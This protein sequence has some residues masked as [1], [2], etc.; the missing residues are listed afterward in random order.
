MKEKYNI[1]S[2]EPRPILDTASYCT[3]TTSDNKVNMQRNQTWFDNW[4]RGVPQ[5]AVSCCYSPWRDRRGGWKQSPL[6]GSCLRGW[7][8]T[9][10]A[11]VDPDHFECG[12]K[13]SWWFS[14]ASTFSRVKVPAATVKRRADY[15]VGSVCLSRSIVAIKCVFL[16]P[17]FLISTTHPSSDMSSLPTCLR[18]NPWSLAQN[19]IALRRVWN[20][21]E[22]LTALRSDESSCFQ[23]IPNLRPW[24]VFIVSNR[25][26]TTTPARK[27][28]SLG[29]T[30]KEL[31]KTSEFFFIS[32][33]SQQTSPSP[34]A[35]LP[36]PFLSGPRDYKSKRPVTA[37]KTI[38]K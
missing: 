20:A 10:T 8:F 3:R 17:T 37:I 13:D 21:A 15:G 9:V 27:I 6:L 19:Q 16:F 35:P 25:P 38:K 31:W 11:M 7:G 34:T 36:S 1:I 30:W 23:F 32:L 2:A 29:F 22:S 14:Y 12:D 33:F 26:G 18:R 4:E 24:P 5:N 28:R